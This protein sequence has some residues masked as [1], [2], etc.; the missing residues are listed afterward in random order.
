MTATRAASVAKILSKEGLTKPDIDRLV[1][2]NRKMF[3]PSAGTQAATMAVTKQATT[4]IM[5]M[6]SE[7]RSL[8]D[9]AR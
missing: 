6:T 1:A 9:Y 8:K 5:Q 2:L 3:Q 4:P 7:K